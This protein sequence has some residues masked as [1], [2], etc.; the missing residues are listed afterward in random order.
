MIASHDPGGKVRL[1]L[2]SD[3]VSAGAFSECR[4]WRWWLERR[5]DGA[6]IGTPGFGVVIGM[7][8]STADLEADDP[9]V[10]GCVFRARH[11]WGLP[12]LVMLNAF[13]YRATD[14]KRL[15]EVED[16]VGDENDATILHYARGAAL[17]VVAWGQPPKPL[18]RRGVALAALLRGAGITPMCFGANNDG[19]PKHP[20]YQKR[21]AILV[22]WNE[23]SKC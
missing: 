3:I 8:P 22:P 20:L 17:V 9:T 7:N 12:G 4:R 1:R 21:D 14:K 23:I 16:P 19:S 6:P 2:A 13:A 11:R 18:M 5:W 15:L 10:A